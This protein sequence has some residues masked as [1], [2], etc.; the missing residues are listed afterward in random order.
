[1]D[2]MALVSRFALATVF[3]LAGLAKLPRRS[4]FEAAVRGY[5]LLP[6][7]LVRPVARLLPPLELAGGLLLGLGIATTIAASALAAALTLFAMAVAVN[8]ARGRTIDC[9]CFGWIAER[10]ITWLT[11]ARNLLL[12]AGAVTAAI[13]GASALALDHLVGNGTANV[14]ASRGFA[15]LLVGTLVAFLA[16]LVDESAR[17]RR[18]LP[19]PKEVEE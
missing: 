8:L 16:L 11:V 5:G 9:G 10:R 2:D 17:L 19:L 12:V 3:V 7:R 15:W 6:S 4:E 18:L 1:M 13:G 14:T